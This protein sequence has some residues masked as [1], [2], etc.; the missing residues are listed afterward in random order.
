MAGLGVALIAS[1]DPGTGTIRKRRLE[2]DDNDGGNCSQPRAGLL[3][4]TRRMHQRIGPVRLRQWQFC[5]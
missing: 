1:A 4:G 3:R 5:I 2:L